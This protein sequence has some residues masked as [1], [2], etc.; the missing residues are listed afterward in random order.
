MSLLAMSS[1]PTRTTLVTLSSKSCWHISPFA[2]F[3]SPVPSQTTVKRTF[4]ISE[5]L[6]PLS[7]SPLTH[8]DPRSTRQEIDEL[9]D[10]W[11]PEPPGAPSLT[12]PAH[13]RRTDRSR[14]GTRRLWYKYPGRNS[15]TRTSSFLILPATT[16]RALLATKLSKCAR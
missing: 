5:K 7:F 3:F 10:E 12:C 16:S 11:T 4:F 6:G 15:P 9:L 1:L 14:V 2:P 8:I 13:S